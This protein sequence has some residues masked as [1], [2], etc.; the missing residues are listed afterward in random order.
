MYILQANLNYFTTQ[1]GIHSFQMRPLTTHTPSLLASSFPPSVQYQF[2]FQPRKY[3]ASFLQ[4]S[5]LLPREH[6]PRW[7]QSQR[8]GMSLITRGLRSPSAFLAHSTRF[9]T[10]TLFLRPCSTLP[11]PLLRL[12][13]PYYTLPTLTFPLSRRKST[14]SVFVLLPPF[15]SLP[16][17]P[18]STIT[19]FPSPPFPS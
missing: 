18:S 13:P 14:P 3:A 11:F 12:F 2:C 7:I 9:A 5:P 16:L 19:T 6:W 10:L 4:T 15:L 1:S 17:L 8:A